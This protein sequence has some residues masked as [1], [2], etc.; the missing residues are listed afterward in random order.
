LDVG[1]VSGDRGGVEMVAVGNQL[2][3]LGRG[4]RPGGQE[5][6]QRGLWL[7]VQTPTAAGLVLPPADRVLRRREVVEPVVDE[8]P[9]PVERAA[10]LAG[11]VAVVEAVLADQ[12]VDLGLDRGLVVR[13]VRPGA[14]EVDVP[15]PR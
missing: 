10:F 5:A 6:V 8:L 3:F 2:A 15:L 7:V 13:L 4:E 9:G 11:V 1:D 14:G 12:V